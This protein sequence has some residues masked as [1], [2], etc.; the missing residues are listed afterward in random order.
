[1]K[2][3]LHVYVDIQ[4]AAV[5]LVVLADADVERGA[6]VAAPEHAPPAPRAVLRARSLVTLARGAGQQLAWLPAEGWLP[7]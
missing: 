3:T 2:I 6:V 5:H 1:M 7:C 4:A